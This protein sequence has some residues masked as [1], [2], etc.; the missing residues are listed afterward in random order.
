[1]KSKTFQIF[2][3]TKKFNFYNTH[4]YYFEDNHQA[5]RK[6]INMTNNLNYKRLCKDYLKKFYEK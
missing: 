5:I 2:Q 1:M 3:F 4:K 6:K